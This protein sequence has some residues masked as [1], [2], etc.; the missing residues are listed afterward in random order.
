MIDAFQPKHS[1]A[2]AMPALPKSAQPPAAQSKSA[3]VVL[4]RRTI[5]SP[6]TFIPRTYRALRAEGPHCMRPFPVGT[7]AAPPSC[8]RLGRLAS[9]HPNYVVR[10]TGPWFVAAS[11]GGWD[12]KQAVHARRRN[13]GPCGT[14]RFASDSS[15][16]STKTGSGSELLLWT[17]AQ[18][19]KLLPNHGW[20][21]KKELLPR[22]RRSIAGLP[23]ARRVRPET[24]R[25]ECHVFQAARSGIVNGPARASGTL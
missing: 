6:V 13:A 25:R 7:T 20:R 18:M 14:D 15:D 22:L 23:G 21:T 12:G 16:W 17:E 5:G 24:A 4:G 8:C 2:T 10:V 9:H 19:R 3:K 1:T 11:S